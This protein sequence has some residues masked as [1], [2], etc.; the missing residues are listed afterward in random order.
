MCAS[1]FCAGVL[2]LPLAGQAAEDN[3][4][5]LKDIQQSIA[6]K[7]KAVKQQQQQRSSLQD[8]LR[9]QEKTS[10]KPAASCATPRARSPSWAKTFP[11]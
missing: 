5:Q 9:Q 10:P 8:Q 2:L 11:A 4:S 6:E 3:K 1:V 7:E